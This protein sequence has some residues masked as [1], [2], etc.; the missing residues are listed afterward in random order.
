[1]NAA[2]ARPSAIVFDWD[3]T[4][5]DTWPTIHEALSV[6]LQAMGHK[7]WTFEET[8]ARVR[9]SLRDSF[10]RMFG[11]RWTEARDIFYDAFE[12][13]HIA[14]L[15][16]IEGVAEML[17][18][19]AATG[20]EMAVLSN[21]TGRYLRDEA[22]H[23]GWTGYFGALVGAGDA[24]RDKPERQALELAL[25]SSVFVP[26]PD[27]WIIGDAGIDMEIAHR[28]DCVPVLLNRDDHDSTEFSDWPPLLVF[29]GCNNV[30]ELVARW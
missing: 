23:L 4:L 14:R 13:N 3:N 26:G 29:N 11:D 28:T 10:P 5:V 19:I 27:I 17:E 22:N 1:M 24:E 20:V 8:T 7:P 21:K 6:T 15:E 16:P 18:A 9:H 30:T 2:P 25:G 12:R